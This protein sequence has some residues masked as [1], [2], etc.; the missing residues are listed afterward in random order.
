MSDQNFLKNWIF[1]ISQ[2]KFISDLKFLLSVL[3]KSKSKMIYYTYTFRHVARITQLEWTNYH[4]H[5]TN[6]NQLLK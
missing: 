5:L 6:T 4:Q 2:K 3:K 1:Y